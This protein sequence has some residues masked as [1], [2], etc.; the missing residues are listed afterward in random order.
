MGTDGNDFIRTGI[1]DDVVF[2]SI[3][4]D[5]FDGGDHADFDLLDFSNIGFGVI[6]EIMHRDDGSSDDPV[7]FRSYRSNVDTTFYNFERISLPNVPSGSSWK[8]EFDFQNQTDGIEFTDNILRID[9]EEFRFDGIVKVFGGAGDDVFSLDRDGDDVDPETEIV[10]SGRGGNDILIG[11]LGED[12][13][14][15]GDGDDTLIGLGSDHASDRFEGGNGN[16]I[17][18]SPANQNND[19]YVVRGGNGKDIMYVETGAVVSGGYDAHDDTLFVNGINMA[20]GYSVF[21]SSRSS[22]YLDNEDHKAL[23]DSDFLIFIDLPRQGT[24]PAQTPIKNML[25]NAY[26]VFDPM[27]ALSIDMDRFGQEYMFFKWDPFRH[28]HLEEIVPQNVKLQSFSFGDY[29]MEAADPDEPFAFALHNVNEQHIYTYPYSGVVTGTESDDSVSGTS[30]R[31]WIDDGAD[32]D[33][34]MA[35][36]GRDLVVASPGNDLIDGGTGGDTVDFSHLSENLVVDL[37]NG[38]ALGAS[39]GADNFISI[40]NVELG[41]GNDTVHDGV[42]NNHITGNDGDDMII[43][44]SGTDIISGG[45]GND[46]FHL[47][48]AMGH[49]SIVD[50]EASDKILLTARSGLNE[51]SGIKIRS[52][53]E[54]HL[55]DL[56]EDLSLLINFSSSLNS[57]HFDFVEQPE[58]P[59]G[60]L[61]AENFTGL[62]DGV[63]SDSGDTAWATDTSLATAGPLHGVSNESYKFSQ[64]GRK[65]DQGR[66]VWI[67]EAI[68]TTGQS[69]VDISF[70]LTSSGTLEDSGAYTDF[71][72]AYY[73][74]DGTGTQFLAHLGDVTGSG[75][76]TFAATDVVAGESLIFEVEAKTSNDTEF[77]LIDDVLIA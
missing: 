26:I 37:A 30:S 6:T 27:E 55:V 2:S 46:T 20:G 62:A 68:D 32:D 48:H 56:H 5:E 52:F 18:I 16:D 58:P 65:N 53:D 7:V 1:D 15:R 21:L 63:T 43:L 39:S 45:A 47:S 28:S 75:S 3:G 60:P 49:K 71:L 74:I 44:S 54:V 41:A 4:I 12:S 61:Y 9:D 40:E 22:L 31:D 8:N 10:L 38:T 33:H 36:G 35:G 70:L 59:T 66:V 34:V 17:L 67:S 42:E 11:T 73:V 23:L 69:T 25:F 50:F 57:S 29:G 51:F 19:V 14:Y 72:N 24:Y 76:Q 77:Y 64:S 13:L